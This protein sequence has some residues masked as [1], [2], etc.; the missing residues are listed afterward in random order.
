MKQQKL[1]K[2]QKEELE[3]F[4]ANTWFVE[5]LHDQFQN[6]PDSLPEQW[7]NFFGRV[8]K[9]ENQNNGN[10]LKQINYPLPGEGDEQKIIAGSAARILDNMENSL[11]IPTATSQ[12]TIPV[13]LLEENR[14]LINNHLKKTSGLK[15]SFT[16]L[17]AWAIIQ[18]IKQNPAL[19]NAFSIVNGKPIIIK[20]KNINLGL[21][22]DIEKKDGTRSLLVPNIKNVE[23]LKF[24]QFISAYDDIVERSR[25]GQID[26]NE[27]LGTTVTLTNPGTIG[28][29]GSIP[30]LMIGQGVIIATGAIQYPAEYQAMSPETISTLGISKVLTIT[31][32]YDHRIIQGAESGFFL[33][34]IHDLLLGK[35]NFYEKIFDDL[36]SHSSQFLG[37]QIFTLKD[38]V[39]RVILMMLKLKLEFFN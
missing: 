12:R 31:S 39:L 35:K 1:T 24:S 22:I 14:I 16:H 34:E 17:I 27:F 9:S 37:R 5:H 13:K 32:T 19:N 25:T 30:R 2:E 15:I 11:T 29:V 21:A 7:Q 23:R 33:K 20:R 4:G 8:S 18:S 28:T 3:K 36:K 10:K 6:N 26:P 38:L